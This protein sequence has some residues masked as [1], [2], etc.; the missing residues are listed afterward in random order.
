MSLFAATTSAT[1]LLTRASGA[2]SLLLLTATFALGIADVARWKSRT[3]PRFAVDA[4]HRNLALLAVAFVGVH[5]FTTLVDQ[6]VSIGVVA[7][8]LPFSNGYKTFFLGLGALA[9]DLLL[10]LLVT[11]VLRH[12]IGVR[13]WRAVHWAA[14]ACLPVAAIHAL[15]TGSDASQPWMLGLA[16]GCA[17]AIAAAIV[18]RLGLRSGDR[19]PGT[20]TR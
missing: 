13:V 3:W 5:V 8:F 19:H 7:A 17:G 2:V 1:W 14:Y 6:F 16:L 11:S 9:F 15:G 10:T 4:L 20:L 12:R 18:A